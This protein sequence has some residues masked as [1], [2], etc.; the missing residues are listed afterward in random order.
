[1]WYDALAE[2]VVIPN[3]SEAK[4]FTTKLI[5]QLTAIEKQNHVNNAQPE[6]IEIQ[7]QH[8]QQLAEISADTVGESNQFGF[9][10]RYKTD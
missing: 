1:L 5:E 8:Q 2:V 9:Q 6:V 10:A 7:Q 3:N 4:A